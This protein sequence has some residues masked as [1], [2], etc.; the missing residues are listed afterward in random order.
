MIV[1]NAGVFELNHFAI[2]ENGAKKPLS[3]LIQFGAVEMAND[4]LNLLAG[5]A[6]Y[7]SYMD[8][9]TTDSLSRPDGEVDGFAPLL[10]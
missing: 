4:F 9:G 8:V 10:F 3:A 5:G 6:V 7:P 1:Q 2:E